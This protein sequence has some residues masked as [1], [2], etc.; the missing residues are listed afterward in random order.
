MGVTVKLIIVL[1][2]LIISMPTYSSQKTKVYKRTIVIKSTNP[3][4][5]AE[6]NRML[7]LILLQAE[8]KTASGSVTAKR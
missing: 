4:V 7:P 5:Y 3:I 6:M 8:A 2:F 1:L